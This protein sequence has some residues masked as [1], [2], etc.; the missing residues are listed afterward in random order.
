MFGDEPLIQ[1][2]DEPPRDI[3][4]SKDDLLM[5]A[6]FLTLPEA[7]IT[8]ASIKIRGL[9]DTR[10]QDTL[11]DAFGG[12]IQ[13]R[14]NKYA[15]WIMDSNKLEVILRSVLPV[16]KES[17]SAQ[18][19]NGGSPDPDFLYKIRTAEH[20]LTRIPRT[21]SSY[22]SV[23]ARRKAQREYQKRKRESQDQ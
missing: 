11:Q 12:R 3:H 4:Y 1:S 15:T 21:K 20:T 22:D 2:L 23:V 5:L 19:K 18:I 14:N 7:E 17:V 6:E 13:N 10:D 9:T 16:M 8:S